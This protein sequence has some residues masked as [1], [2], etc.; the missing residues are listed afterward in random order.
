MAISKAERR[1]QALER[2]Q[3]RDAARDEIMT[4]RIRTGIGFGG[5]YIL[6]Q[7]LPRFAPQLDEPAPGGG[8][9]T[10]I[11]LVTLG[12]GAYLAFT[13]DG[14]LGDFGL[15]AMLVGATQT[16]DRVTTTIEGWLDNP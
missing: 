6:T 9:S 7:I 8:T 12:G 4:A 11:D 16:L 3:K 5:A 15:G 10:V 13:D 14:E 1:A 2:R